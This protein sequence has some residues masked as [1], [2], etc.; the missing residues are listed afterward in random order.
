MPQPHWQTRLQSGLVIPACPLMLTEDGRWS[1][2]HQRAV[3]RYYCDAGAGGLAVGV[4]STQFAIR[5]PRHN[6]LEPVL[7][8]AAE[9]LQRAAE[10]RR[11][12]TPLVRIAGV[13]GDATQAVA[14]ARLANSLRYD[15]GLLSLTAVG[16]ESEERILEH[17]R[18]VAGEIPIIGFYLQPA[19]G[20]RVY[21]FRF[22]R[23]FC[24]IPEVVAIKIAP[25]NRYQT[26]DV[27][28]AV[29]E[30][31]RDDVALYTG[32][33]DNIIVDLLTPFEFAGARRFIAGGL[34]GQWGVWT[35]EAVIM[36]Q[37]IHAARRGEQLQTDWLTRAAAL[38]DANAAVFDAANAFAGCIPGIMEVLR[39]QGLAPSARCLDPQETLSDGQAEELDRIA[40]DYPWI[41]D[42]AFVAAN[43]HRWLEE[44]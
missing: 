16:K 41:S 7:R 8:V 40:H 29:I 28:R 12:E 30:S 4:H 17:C 23:R 18:R 37:Q 3:V 31:H 42:D 20:G 19:V 34:L 24:E 22:W 26:L 33:D 32:N 13:C 27:V 6:L 36:L 11:R 5:D 15:A 10:D 21:S 14:E 44:L 39:R 38:T 25:F 1:Q 43:L 35:R 2:R 9:E